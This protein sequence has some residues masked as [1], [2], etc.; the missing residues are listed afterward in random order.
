MTNALCKGVV[1]EDGGFSRWLLG[2]MDN[3]HNWQGERLCG[4]IGKG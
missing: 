3:H 4:Q 2:N 1:P